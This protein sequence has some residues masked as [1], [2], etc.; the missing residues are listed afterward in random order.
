MAGGFRTLAR[1]GLGFK[2]GRT[3]VSGARLSRRPFR[4]RRQAL[5]GFPENRGNGTPDRRSGP[6]SKNWR[7]RPG[8][9]GR[10]R[11][12]I[13]P[14]SA[15]DQTSQKRRRL[16]RERDSGNARSANRQLAVVERIQQG[17]AELLGQFAGRH[18]GIVLAAGVENRANRNQ[19]RSGAERTVFGDE[20]KKK[21]ITFCK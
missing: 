19:K 21:A 11:T 3:G 8:A 4:Q 20:G 6:R 1:R 13:R 18:N 2:Q 5:R 16:P 17:I 10:P 14:I 15:G 12:S 9:E 7:W